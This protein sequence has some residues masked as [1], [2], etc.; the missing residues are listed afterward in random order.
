MLKRIRE[1]RKIQPKNFREDYV[2]MDGEKVKTVYCKLTGAELQSTREIGSRE[3]LAP[4]AA[5]KEIVLKFTD[6][7]QHVTAISPDGIKAL[8][9]NALEAIYAADLLQW[10]KEVK[11]IPETWVE[12]KINGYEVVD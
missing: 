2:E 9:D 5:Y 7:S 6:G 1:A 11:T 4:T 10:S 8:D 3:M 12:R